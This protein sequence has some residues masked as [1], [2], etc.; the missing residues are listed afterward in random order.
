MYTYTEH[1]GRNA[2]KE[3]IKDDLNNVELTASF[4]KVPGESTG[5]LSAATDS[6]DVE[7]TDGILTAVPGG[8]WAVRIEG[9]PLR[10]GELFLCTS[11]Q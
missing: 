7:V 9:K 11:P 6:L 4:L 3:V 10:N 5:E 2:G 8:S 1:D